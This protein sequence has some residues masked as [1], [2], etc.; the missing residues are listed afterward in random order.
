MG[1]GEGRMG[2]GRVGGLLDLE[3]SVGCREDERR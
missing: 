2:G 3:I 1:L